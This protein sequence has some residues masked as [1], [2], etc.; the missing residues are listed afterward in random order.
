MPTC[1]GGSF[2]P[3]HARRTVG[4]TA[5]ARIRAV[6]PLILIVPGVLALVGGIVILR[7]FGPAYR[8][9]R[10]L[11]ATPVLPLPEVI[12]LADGPERY[13][14]V[15]G[16]IDAEDPFEDENHRPLVLRRTRLAVRSG[17]GWRT[18]DEQREAVP[19]EV[20]EGLDGLAV[21]GDALD[22][23]LVVMPRESVGTAADV[24]DRVPADTPPEREVRLRVEHVSAIDHAV[25]IGV[26]RRAADG[27]VRMTAGRGRPLI[28][29]TMGSDEAMRVLAGGDGRR[30][31]AAAISLGAGLVLLT[32]G[33]AWALLGA[34][35]QVALAASPEP[36]TAP[37]GDPRSAGQG[38]GLVGEPLVAIG[39]VVAI[40]VVAAVATYAWVRMTR[41]PEPR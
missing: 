14:G 20:R 9:A 30:T 6:T 35:T 11:A 8:V 18:V 27:L 36:S 33:L 7:S 12:A 3:F 13:V 22:A 28:L 37:G 31:L 26:P 41:P 2:G 38:P 21:D 24:M 19:F 15:E 23:G 25:V 5:G 32:V 29:S 1:R 39:L 17:Q 4:A 40:G 10:L 34:M 16:R